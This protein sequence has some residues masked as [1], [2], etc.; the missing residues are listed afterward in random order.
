MPL[1]SI[2]AGIV[3]IV[4][5]KKELAT[6]FDSSTG[7]AERGATVTILLGVL[8]AF[9]VIVSLAYA[10]VGCRNGKAPGAYERAMSPGNAVELMMLFLGGL[11]MIVGG[12][13]YY[14]AART[15]YAAGLYSL[16]FA[17][18]A[19]ASGVCQVILASAA[20][21]KKR[22]EG[23][24]IAS[25]VTPLF[26]CLW[27][28]ATYR[29]YGTE[30]ALLTYCGMCV[31]IIA[32]T[33]SFY[34]NAGFAFGRKRLRSSVFF[35]LTAIY[36]CTVALADFTTLPTRLVL[37]GMILTMSINTASLVENSHK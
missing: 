34:F 2:I 26:L 1:I 29:S 10:V 19:A 16:V 23:M 20:Y 13:V 12:V 24:G 22:V 28:V 7:L 35:G 36:M 30:P 15:E 17:V 6:V 11:A 21:R 9:I 18:L 4:L 27:L 37:F 32:A 8:S 14:F 33:L 3:G 31:A 25:V 5:R